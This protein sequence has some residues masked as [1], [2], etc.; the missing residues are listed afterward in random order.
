MI[1]TILHL[2]TINPVLPAQ[3]DIFDTIHLNNSVSTAS[4]ACHGETVISAIGSGLAAFVCGHATASSSTI[5]IFVASSRLWIV[6]HRSASALAITSPLPRDYAGQPGQD[7][8]YGSNAHL[9][10]VAGKVILTSVRK[11]EK[12]VSV[13]IFSGVD[14]SILSESFLSSAGPAISPVAR[15]LDVDT[16]MHADLQQ[17]QRHA[18]DIHPSQHKTRLVH[19]NRH[20]VSHD[21]PTTFAATAPAYEDNERTR[22][23]KNDSEQDDRQE[24]RDRNGGRLRYTSGPKQVKTRARQPM[25]D[26]D[27]DLSHALVRSIRSYM[28]AASSMRWKLATVGDG[29]GAVIFAGAACIPNFWNCTLRNSTVHPNS[30]EANNAGY[31][32]RTMCANSNP[33][34]S[35]PNLNSK[36]V[37]EYEDTENPLRVTGSHMEYTWVCCDVNMLTPVVCSVNAHTFDTHTGTFSTS[38]L[39]LNMSDDMFEI[40]SVG[41]ATVVVDAVNMSNSFWQPS[42]QAAWQRVPIPPPTF[43]AIPL[44]GTGISWPANVAFLPY[45]RATSKESV[46]QQSQ[47]VI[48]F[49]TEVRLQQ[50][51]VPLLKEHPNPGGGS[52]TRACQVEG[53][54]APETSIK[55]YYSSPG[56]SNWGEKDYKVSFYR[57][58]LSFNVVT[59]VWSHPTV[60]PKRV[61]KR[62][63]GQ[64][65]SHTGVFEIL[66]PLVSSATLGSKLFMIWQ[67]RISEAVAELIIWDVWSEVWS[68]P[69]RVHASWYHHYYYYYYSYYP[70]N[71]GFV[72]QFVLHTGGQGAVLCQGSY[73]VTCTN[74]DSSGVMQ[75]PSAVIEVSTDDSTMTPSEV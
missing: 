72:N 59:G 63:T 2:Q 14:G 23:N 71:Q 34:G 57:E 46:L 32:W 58:T 43:S 41:G 31:G 40:G 35:D 69:V 36:Q 7:G 12:R 54:S 27:R 10:C 65:G 61:V 53:W 26:R 24:T 4:E 22:H 28:S 5:D 70:G 37:L 67:D 38:S 62:Q 11:G 68:V 55:R 1:F 51:C 15:R 50:E 13:E 30:Y 6:A 9:A 21:A 49:V 64:Q 16:P 56:W 47:S 52:V 45:T 17:Y 33:S 20:D 75:S 66:P 42:A 18:E 73:P 44:E 25:E 8:R 3:I 74:V 19:D 60:V 39:P 48:H 29:D